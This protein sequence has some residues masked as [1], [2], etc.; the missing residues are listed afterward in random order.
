[1]LANTVTARSG[2]DLGYPF[3]TMGASKEATGNTS[4]DVGGYYLNPAGQGEPPGRWAGRGLEQFGLAP[5]SEVSE[6]TFKSIY[7][8][9]HP[10]TGE[11]LGRKPS[12]HARFDN[13]LA[14]LM[15]AEPHATAE[16]V[17]ELR[18]EAAQA[19]RASSA[20]VDVTVE[21][22]KSISLMHASI[23]EN[24]YHSKLTG[25]TRSLE[26]WTRLETEFSEALQAANRAGMEYA[27]EHAGYTRTGN[28]TRAEGK[29][30]GRYA[31]ADLV[32]ASFQQGT[33]RAGDM[34][35]HEHNLFW[36][37]V[38]TVDDGKV[39]ALDTMSLRS[40]LPAIQA[41]VAATGEAELSRRF[42]FEWADRPD[43][44]GREIKGVSPELIKQ[45]SV[46]SV[47]VDD[48][49]RQKAAEWER[50]HGT[51][52]SEAQMRYMKDAAWYETRAGKDEGPLDWD[53]H[54]ARWD[55]TSGGT[56]AALF[57]SVSAASTSASSS[58]PSR[59]KQREAMRVAL[60]RVQEKSGT[61]TRMDLA[62]AMAA[63]L[64]T[65]RM[66]PGKAA[67]LVM[68][69]TGRA[70]GGEVSHVLTTD[71]PEYPKLP[72][73][74]RRDADGRSVY[75]RPWSQRYSTGAQLSIE[76]RLVS[77]ASVMGSPVL[78]RQALA[79]K[80]GSTPEMLEAQLKLRAAES[81]EVL[82]SGLRLDQAAALFHVLTTPRTAN[83]LVGPGGSG[84]SHCAA[85]ASN[86]WKELTGKDVIG[87]TPSQASRNVLRDM[88]MEAYNFADYLGH[89]KEERGARGQYDIEP[90][91]LL[92]L[93]E[94]SMFSTPDMT[95]IIE[96]AVRAGA[97][98]LVIGD[99]E[100]LQAVESGGGMML[101]AAENEY[102][103]LS[104]PVRFRNEW[105]RDAT[106]NLRAGNTDVLHTYEEHGRLRGGTREEVMDATRRDYV[107]KYI[108]GNDVLL[109][110]ESNKLCQ[111]LSE[112]IRSD[113]IHLGIVDQDNTVEL[114]NGSAASPGDLI[115]NR[116][117]NYK[118]LGIANGD[119]L[120]IDSFKGKHAM[121]SKLE[122]SKDGQRVYGESSKVPQEIIT[123]T[124]R[125][126][127]A[128]TGHCAQGR[129]VD[130]G[131]AIITGTEDRQWAY[132]AGS[133]GRESNVF[134]VVTPVTPA[135]P[136]KGTVPAPSIARYDRAMRERG[137]MPEPALTDQELKDRE[138]RE[139]DGRIRDRI[140]VMSD[141]LERDGTQQS[142]I[143]T[144]RH[145]LSLADDLGILNVILT[146]ET[147]PVG[148]S[149]TPRSLRTRYPMS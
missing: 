93:D 1:M 125:L 120:R 87:V 100:Q 41:V 72:D 22:S 37:K 5:G 140:A 24:M 128:V 43:G 32:I 98:A 6:K 91:T 48:A 106:L 127:Y 117:S 110:A 133:R 148:T 55:K 99:H 27:Q 146:E 105:E 92:I 122:G 51:P 73:S 13:H 49:V 76:Q 114:Q 149:G 80:L 118:E 44:K 101:L 94:S 130:A 25:D 81:R 64:D 38:F 121:V 135:D 112:Q 26:Y 60:Q 131:Q 39:R 111:E 57:P 28:H 20:Y 85:F 30:T 132:V 104:T 12:N 29:D 17:E 67:G 143:Q 46:R 86:V 70:L 16:R 59:G 63:S 4:K 10:E 52:P 102:V 115:I 136:E 36:S 139:Q 45:F 142:A 82:S 90:G 3:K 53:K 9:K 113:L 103:Q 34:H 75:T 126:G 124:C 8:G 108:S 147:R 19:T 2:V 50:D 14:R 123:S 145:E 107:A 35:D 84:K 66:D 78:D 119:T 89:T 109:M 40:Q 33:S 96:G 79:G 83:V 54:A 56:L 11:Q 65:S 58:G 18:R 68:D 116:D 7:S 15:A 21:W 47:Q 74:L 62:K 144:Q 23:R 141:V 61:W 95:D 31:D 88:G 71:A 129:T 138:E 137:A 42:G 134:Y 77:A 97:H 69:L